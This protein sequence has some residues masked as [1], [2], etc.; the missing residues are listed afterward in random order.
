[1]IHI[2]VI[3]A[4]ICAIQAVEPEWWDRMAA[5]QEGQYEVIATSTATLSGSLYSVECS[6]VAYAEGVA[7]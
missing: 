5:Q 1:M 4:M 3:R 2:F 6:T 7:L